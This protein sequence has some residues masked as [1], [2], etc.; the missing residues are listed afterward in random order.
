MH[1]RAEGLHFNAFHYYSKIVHI[2]LK[3]SLQCFYILLKCCIGPQLNGW[4]FINT[5]LINTQPFN[6]MIGKHLGFNWVRSYMYMYMYI[7]C[8]VHIYVRVC[9]CKDILDMQSSQIGLHTYMYVRTNMYM[10]VHVYV[11]TCMNIIERITN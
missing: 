5:Q 10:Y 3:V 4:V 7:H 11:Y 8:I 2:V 9:D 1:A 6:I